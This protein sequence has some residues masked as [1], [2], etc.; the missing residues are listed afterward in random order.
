MWIRI[1]KT[2]YIINIEV[3]QDTQ[4]TLDMQYIITCLQSNTYSLSSKTSV[5]TK[6]IGLYYTESCNR[7]LVQHLH[8]DRNLS[9][10][11]VESSDWLHFVR[12]DY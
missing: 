3:A 9:E 7:K 11:Q 2:I 1:T 6:L 5:K 10:H 12:K 4:Y 8:Y